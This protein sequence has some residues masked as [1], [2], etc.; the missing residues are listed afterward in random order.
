MFNA[1]AVFP[2]EGLAASNIK[3][4]FC[5][6]A[7]LASKSLKPVA[8]PVTFPLFW[9]TSSI[10]SKAF[11]VISLMLVNSSVRRFC[12]ISNIPFSA[13]SI[14]KLTSSFAS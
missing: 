10:F 4:D 7:V 3:S 1:N 13:F 5:S 12:I 2:I 9:Y 8:M 14:I 6:P 11:T